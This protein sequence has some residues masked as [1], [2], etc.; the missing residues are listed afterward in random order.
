VLLMALPALSLPTSGA[1]HVLEAVTMLV[2]VQ[3]VVGRRCISQSR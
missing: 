1:T 3:P 2:A